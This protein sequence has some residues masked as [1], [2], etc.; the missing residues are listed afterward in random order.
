MQF[1]GIFQALIAFTMHY[2]NHKLGRAPRNGSPFICRLMP[3]VG[4]NIPV[5]SPIIGRNIPFVWNRPHGF[6]LVELIITLTI[7]GIMAAVAVPSMNNIIQDHRL[8]GQVNDLVGDINYARSEAVK[9]G[10]NI[11]ICKQDSSTTNPQC[12][13]T[14]SAAWSAG[15][16]IFIDTDGDG[17]VDTSP[18]PGETVLR[19]R[20]RLSGNNTLTSAGTTEN[21]A[22]PNHNAANRIVYTSTGLTTIITNEEAS[23]RFCDSRG[24]NKTLTVLI[25]PTGRSRIDRTPPASC[26]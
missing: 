17:Q 15:R 9:R 7:I 1:I 25:N 8:S 11:T 18:A 21:L 5:V 6:T 24:V 3:F 13:T 19:N 4:L 26:P 12:N 10:A 16:V 22:I 20:E 2:P 23:L 14:T